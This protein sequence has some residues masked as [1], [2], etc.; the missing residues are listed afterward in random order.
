MK[1][2]LHLTFSILVTITALSGAKAQATDTTK[3][4]K[5]LV[6]QIN[7]LSEIDPAA[8]R[9]VQSGFKEA[10][11]MQA[12]L[13]LIRMNT[14]GGMLNSADSIRTKIL[15]SPIPVWIFI[16]NQ[17]ASA[18]ALI[19]I[20]ADR[21][22]MRKGA[23]IGAATVVNQTGEALPDKYQSFM[24]AMMRATAESHGKDTIISGKDTTYRWRRDPLIAEAMVDPRT[25]IPGIIDST[26]VLTF[27][28]LEAI[29]N[30][31]CEGE[32]E[33]VSEVL[34]MGGVTNYEIHEQRITGLDSIMG[35]LLN[36]VVQ[37]ILIIL[38]FAGIYFE[39][40]TPG[41]GFPIILAI[42]AAAVYFAPLYLEGLAE[43]WEIVM[44]LVGLVLIAIEVFAIPGFGIV[45]VAGI[46]LTFLGLTL[47]M[48]DNDLFKEQGSVP[49]YLIVQPVVIV[50]LSMFLSLVMV[51][52]LSKNLFGNKRSPLYRM[53][54][55]ARLT[56]QEG[57]VGVDLSQKNMVGKTGVAVSVL[58][59]SGKVEIE[60]EV[61]DAISTEGFTPKG[62]TVVV[63]KSLA[64]QLY[65]TKP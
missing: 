24:R 47:S 18:G 49:A 42:I 46:V 43:N 14:Y 20:A 52:F 30:H 23:S 40:Q 5:Q 25:V 7:I 6:Y 36:P 10:E 21:I 58:R 56:E 32:A 57:F 34:A 59:P 9:M 27:T 29:K 45:G 31:Y 33:S 22:Y 65:V 50:S 17:A 3:H 16:D 19:S 12:N 15:N 61:Y 60:G 54:L 38:I 37:G 26:K 1:T 62:E 53:A 64:G 51:L 41:I 35:W 2:L 28:T 63:K 55:H 4:A 13:V 44:F 39:L 48:I 8:W 11:I